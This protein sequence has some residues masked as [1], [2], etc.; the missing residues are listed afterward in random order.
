MAHNSTIS[1]RHK[2]HGMDEKRVEPDW[3]PLTLAEVHA[4]LSRFYDLGDPVQILSTSPRPFSAASVVRTTV[5]RVFIKRHSRLVRD[6]EGLLEE[7]RFLK[8]LRAH[9]AHVPHVYGSTTGE[10]VIET[11]E[12]TYEV[13]E[14]PDGVDIYEDA[15]SWTPFRSVAHANS[16]GRAL[17]LLHL[18]SRGFDAPRRKP[19]PLVASFTIFANSDPQREAARYLEARSFLT[20][21]AGVGNC[22]R[23]ALRLLTSF[24]TELVPLLPELSPL[25]THNDLHASNLMWSND[26]DEARATAIFDFG[27]ADRT[28]AVHD[29]AHAIQRNIVEWLALGKNRNQPEAV[30][31]HLDHLHALLDGYEAVRPLSTAEAAA[32]APMTAL[33]HA[34][35]ALSEADYFLGILHSQE[36]AQSAY[37]GWLVK[38]A[39]WFLGSGG[40]VLLDAIRQRSQTRQERIVS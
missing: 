14:A 20:G 27:L 38:H 29:I 13:H 24:H 37:Y 31:I 10:T 32:L 36:K 17:A 19:R 3:Q 2:T 39:L 5:G 4:L 7:H 25:W 16:A 21:N 9:G 34:E 6:R 12:S 28:C 8:H 22:T 33:C 26:S 23:E 35:F 40:I 1:T 15:L 30:P 18:A 11:A